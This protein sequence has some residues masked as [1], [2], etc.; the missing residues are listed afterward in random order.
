MAEIPFCNGSAFEAHQYLCIDNQHLCRIIHVPGKLY[1]ME[2][3]FVT[4][5]YRTYDCRVPV[6]AGY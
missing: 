4:Q 5:K 3:E 1:A 2:W 6:S